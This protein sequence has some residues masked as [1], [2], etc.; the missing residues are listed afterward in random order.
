MMVHW[1]V[2]SLQLHSTAYEYATILAASGFKPADMSFGGGFAKSSAIYKGL[3]LGAPFTKLIIMGRAMMIPGFLGSN[4]EGVLKPANKARVN[5]NWT[6]LPKSVSQ[7]GDSVETIFTGYHSLKNKIG[8]KA[9]QEI[10]FGAIAMWTLTDKLAAGLQQFMAGC[11]R[12]N[13]NEIRREDIAAGNYEVARE[14]G[15]QHICDARDDF[16]KAI[17]NA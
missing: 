10:P 13:M 16:A 4:I 15:L 6:E 12:F 5:G 9:I 11:R 7:F 17:L 14:T 3:A 8:E 1:G 2:P